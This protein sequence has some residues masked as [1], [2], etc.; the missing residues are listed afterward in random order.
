MT[1]YW[2]DENRVDEDLAR[3]HDEG[4]CPCDVCQSEREERAR[5]AGILGDEP[6]S[7]HDILTGQGLR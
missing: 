4:N 2:M 6:P 1:V 7:E 5:A 3:L